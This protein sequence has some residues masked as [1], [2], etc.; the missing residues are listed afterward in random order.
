MN[1]RH[2]MAAALWF[3]GAFLVGCSSDSSKPEKGTGGE[4]PAQPAPSVELK[5]A[6]EADKQALAKDNNAFALDLY[7]KLREEKGNLFLSP[8]SLSSALAMTY[9]GARGQTAAQMAKALHFDLDAPRLHAAFA[10]LRSTLGAAGKSAGCELVVANALWAQQDCG[11]LKELLALTR[12]AYGAAAQEVDFKAA[13][14]AR[15]TINAW[16]EKETRGKIQDLIPPDVLDAM[17]V[18]VLTNAIYF[19]G[20]WAMPFDERGTEDAPF[21][22][23]SG[24]KVTVPM[25]RRTEEFGYLKGEGFQALEMRY[26]GGAFSMFVF[27]P[28]KTDGLPEFEKS[29]AADKL[30]AWMG[31][32]SVKEVAV[33][34][35]QFKLTSAFRLDEALKAL[36]L[37]D[38]FGVGADFSGMNGR[39]DLFIGAV[40]HKAFVD[41]NEA[42]TEAAAA[43]AVEMKKSEPMGPPPVFRADHPF[44]FLIRHNPSGSI[45]FLGRLV[46]PKE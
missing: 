9:A 25:M 29:L 15:Q 5:P 21:T 12:A 31:G 34:L 44:L 43:T 19:K 16:V 20:A 38:P 4:P 17:T 26:R 42:G 30:A 10:D 2:W 11:L 14:K 1:A 27:L 40:L 36:G 6:P 46:N 24:E 35:P 13:E 41:V 22:L 18:L 33:S 7:A 39:K 23:L 32:T 3:L 37:G 8:Y 45:L 28:A